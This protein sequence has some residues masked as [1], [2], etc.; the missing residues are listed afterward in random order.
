MIGY[1]LNRGKPPTKGK[2]MKKIITTIAVVILVGCGPAPSTE[3]AYLGD[4]SLTLQK[5][6]ITLKLGSDDSFS[7]AGLGRENIV[8][9]WKEKGDLLV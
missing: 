4:Y 6:T 3:S 9:A 2:T 5:E 7:L 8:G 1:L